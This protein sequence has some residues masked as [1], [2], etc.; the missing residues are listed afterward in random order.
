MHSYTGD[1]LRA[2][3][4]TA[5]LTMHPRSNLLARGWEY[6][7]GKDR[8]VYYRRG[9]A[10]RKRAIDPI[11]V[12]VECEIDA[13]LIEALA[14][15]EDVA[16]AEREFRL[17]AAQLAD[18]ADA[19]V[20]DYGERAAASQAVTAHDIGHIAIDQS[21]NLEQQCARCVP[22]AAANEQAVFTLKGKETGS[23][24]SVLAM[25]QDKLREPFS[26]PTPI[27]GETHDTYFRRLSEAFANWAN[28]RS[29]LAA[30]VP[31]APGSLA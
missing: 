19:L 5:M 6:R 29:S 11:V 21:R 17:A 1:T 12:E 24:F 3:F 4:C 16:F 14:V 8:A 31:H 22:E 7:A 18:G 13:S 10:R 9:L 27:Y 20:E 28:R 23:G 26:A 2:K 25:V 15:E 30:L